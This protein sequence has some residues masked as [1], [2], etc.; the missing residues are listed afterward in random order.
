MRKV[1]LVAGGSTLGRAVVIL[2]SPFLTRL[3]T[4]EDFGL[5]AVYTALLGILGGVVCWRYELAV[6]LPASRRT[7]A[8]VLVLCLIIAAAMS[9]FAAVVV[10]LAREQIAGWLRVPGLAPYLWLLPLGL[11]AVGSYQALTYWAIR[12]QAFGR[13]ARTH[14][15]Q[16]VG[17]VAVQ[18]G[19]GLGAAGPLGLLFGAVVGQATGVGTLARAAQREDAS[20]FRAVRLRALRRVLHRYR[21][22]PLLASGAVLLNS[23]ARRLPALLLAALY[24]PQVA[25]FYALSQRVVGS[26]MQLIGGAV[27]QVYVGHAAPLIRQDAPRLRRLCMRVAGRMLLVG[28]VLL[29]AI[30]LGGPRLFELA[31]GA[32]WGEAGRYVQVLLVAYLGQFAVA[33]IAQTLHMLERQDVNLVW[34][35][36]Q[37]AGIGL[38]F[39]L[40]YSAELSAVWLLALYSAGMALSHVVSFMLILALTGRRVRAPQASRPGVGG[41]Q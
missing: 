22:F 17:Q 20:A 13:L 35:G 12:G 7:A 6:P 14:I 19:W 40:G 21:R 8:N 28:A 24:G 39:W 9:L 31:F 29:G 1:A 27:G 11:L 36:G 3:F 37:V 4:P 33:P 10:T 34:N 38:I 5:L 2:A 23:S 15:S 16:G 41:Q 18:V 30:G 32:G 26:P 25:G